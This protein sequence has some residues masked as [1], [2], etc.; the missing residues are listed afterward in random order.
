MRL[1]DFNVK[2]FD[3]NGEIVNREFKNA[4]EFNWPADGKFFYVGMKP[5][6][7]KETPGKAE[8]KTYW[9]P[10]E[11]IIEVQGL[12]TVKFD[13]LKERKAFYDSLQ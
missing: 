7:S 5:T 3:E 1:Y 12:N 11:Q 10:V 9:I 13:T 6:L 8:L 4:Y 2:M